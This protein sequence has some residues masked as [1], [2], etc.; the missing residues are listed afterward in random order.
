VVSADGKGYKDPSTAL[1][2]RN[3]EYFGGV[4]MAKTAVSLLAG[5]KTKKG[6]IFYKTL[7][8]G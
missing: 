1:H 6:I 3:S 2:E 5:T 4:C 7:A 8:I